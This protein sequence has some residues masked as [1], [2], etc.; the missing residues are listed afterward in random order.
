L[1]GR[2]ADKDLSV[3]LDED[4]VGRIGHP[5]GLDPD[6]VR[7]DLAAGAE[8]V[9]QGPVR[10]E[11]ATANSLTV[12]SALC[13]LPATTILPSGWRAR[14][15]GELMKLVNATVARPPV[16]KLVSGVPLLR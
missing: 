10:V 5:A 11:A 9:A 1:A 8:A 3:G 12:P 16:P 6:E 15:L 14:S 7:G 2:P 13:A 4:R